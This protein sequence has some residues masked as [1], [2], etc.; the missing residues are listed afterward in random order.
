MRILV[1]TREQKPLSFLEET[2]VE[3][4][5]YGDY[6][7]AFSGD[8]RSS[9]FFERKSIG[10]LYGTMSKGYERF[11]KE[12]AKAKAN[13]DKLIIIVEGTFLDVLQGYKHSLRNPSTIL[14]Q[15]FTI[16]VR[17]GVETVF[18]SSRNEMARYIVHYYQAQY[19]EF[20][21]RTGQRKD[22]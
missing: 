18:C 10:D 14:K 5:P 16:R 9:T 19:S 1:D 8:T 20:L 11:K 6:C 17:H 12:M 7:A 3:V 21:Y 22:F 2:S 4:L 13:N 15:L